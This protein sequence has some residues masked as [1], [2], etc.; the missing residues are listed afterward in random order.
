MWILNRVED[1]E[2][3]EL[4]V[5]VGSLGMTVGELGMTVGRVVDDGWGVGDD[6]WES[7]GRMASESVDHCPWGLEEG[8]TLSRHPWPSTLRHPR[9]RSGIQMSES[10]CLW[11]RRM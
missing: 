5:T 3:G 11:F 2:V 4:R 9:P 1:D 8:R 7:C 10:E 6:G